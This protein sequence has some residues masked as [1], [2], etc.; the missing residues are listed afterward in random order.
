MGEAREATR[1]GWGF[2]TMQNT[3]LCM[4]NTFRPFSIQLAAG[5]SNSNP[6]SSLATPI[7]TGVIGQAQP[8]RLS[9]RAKH[10]S[11]TAMAPTADAKTDVRSYD[12]A[13][14]WEAADKRKWC[15]S[16]KPQNC[17]GKGLGPCRQLRA[18]MRKCLI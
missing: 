15:V 14:G 12:Y 2:N 11:S 9:V 5:I 17:V 6:S 8:Q 10:S 18:Y 1:W 7:R 3:P 16:A 13:C 4:E